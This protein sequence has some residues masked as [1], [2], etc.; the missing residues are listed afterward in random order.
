MLLGEILHKDVIKTS[1]VA[2]EKYEA[3]EELINLLVKAGDIPTSMSEG[4]KEVVFERER[5]MSTGMEHGVALPHGTVEDI[6]DIVGALGISRDGLAFE[7]IDG[8]PAR[9]IILLLLPTRNYPG[10]VRTLAGIAHLLNNA[11]LREA[12]ASA[13]EV[14]GILKLIEA[15]EVKDTFQE[16]RSS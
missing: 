10:H 9:L 4:V 7:S 1:L 12:L 13:E 3:I 5:S 14:D 8:N 16:F 15:E 11:S 2:R 6:E